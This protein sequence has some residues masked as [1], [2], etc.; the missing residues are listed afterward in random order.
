LKWIPK[1]IGKI[2][3]KL[4]SEF[5]ENL[6]SFEDAK[7]LCG[8]LTPNYL[9][10]L[11][12]AQAVFIFEK[13]LR[14]RVYRLVPPNLFL[15]ALAYSVDMGWLI[16]ST[17]ANL[18]L[19]VFLALKEKFRQNLLSLGVYGSIARNKAKKES[20]LDIF[21]VFKEIQGT[22][23]ERI[24]ILSEIE[25]AEIIQS[26][27]KFLREKAYF[28][29]ISFYPRNESELRMSF[30]T[31]DIAFDMKIVYDTNALRNFLAKIQKKIQEKGIQRK[32][33]DNERYYLDLNIKFGDVFEF[34]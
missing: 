33:L 1:W 23:S 4:W 12:K 2:Y 19:K 5:G 7:K 32:Y 8:Y 15:Y 34:E 29:R 21:L 20:D 25:K 11:K 16:Q 31:I 3:C 18:I 27:I 9:S 17:Y 10:E 6:F 14:K 30:F 28:P 13:V 22:V 26:E 24:D